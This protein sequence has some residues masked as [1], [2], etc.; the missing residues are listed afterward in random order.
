MNTRQQE[1]TKWILAKAFCKR[2]GYSE[3]AI[4][5]KRKKGTWPDGIITQIRGRR[6][7]V[8]MM[9]YYHWVET[10][11]FSVFQWGSFPTDR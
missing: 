11:T 5:M 6:L 3:E 10:G 9:E 8:N 7:H 1:T 2:T 4:K